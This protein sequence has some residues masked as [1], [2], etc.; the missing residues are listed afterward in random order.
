MQREYNICLLLHAITCLTVF[1][2]AF[3]IRYKAL[4]VSQ[5]NVTRYSERKVFYNFG[6]V[7]MLRVTH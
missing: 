1:T 5:L 3:G 6:T 2:V 4:G 7:T